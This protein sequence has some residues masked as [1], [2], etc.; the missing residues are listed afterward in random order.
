MVRKGLKT[1]SRYLIQETE[2]YES[3]VRWGTDGE[4]R[5]LLRNKM[6]SYRSNTKAYRSEGAY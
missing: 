1:E 4:R 6:K 5:E 3:K 2:Y